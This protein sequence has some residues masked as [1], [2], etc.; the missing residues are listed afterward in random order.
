MANF[1][2]TND[3]TLAHIIE[4]TMG[5]TPANPAMDRIRVDGESLG[6]AVNFDEADEINPNYS[7][8]DLVAV[9]SEA[10]GTFPIEFAKSAALDAILEATLRGTWTTNVLK[11]GTVKRSFTLEKKLLG[12]GSAKYMKFPG[13][14]YTSLTLTGATGSRITGTVG[15]MS[16]SGVDSL[17]SVVG[18]G[19][20][21]EPAD[22]RIM[23]MVDI[24]ALTV[25]G[26]VTPLIAR[27]FTISIDNN[28]R[29]QNGH[30]QLASYDIAYGMRAITLSMDCYFESWEQMDN[31]LNRTNQNIIMTI[32]DGVNSYS[33]RFPRMRYRTLTANATGNNTDLVQTIEG[34]ALYDPTA[35]VLTD[36]QITRAP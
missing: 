28:A 7:L 27:G 6:P 4:T 23:S 18:T 2:S 10:G 29:R 35:G 5:V 11:A 21:A 17:T 22:N 30:G 33:F 13:S 19:S 34:R 31:L 36:L 20:V 15:V 26:A 16:L 1:G 9:S 14:R 32:G 12:G 25:T 3:L 8:S 24:S